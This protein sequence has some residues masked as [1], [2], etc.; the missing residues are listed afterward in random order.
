MGRTLSVDSGLWSSTTPR[1]AKDPAL[2]CAMDCRPMKNVAGK[3]SFM[4][5]R[6][7][8]K[9]VPLIRRYCLTN[10]KLKKTRGTFGIVRALGTNGYEILRLRSGFRL[11]A[12][13]A[14]TPAKRL[15]LKI[16]RSERIVGVRVSPSPDHYFVAVLPTA[17]EFSLRKFVRAT[18]T[19]GLGARAGPSP[20]EEI[21]CDRQTGGHLLHANRAHGHLQRF[22]RLAPDQRRTDF[23]SSAPCG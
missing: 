20:G 17:K 19:A 16:R 12:P 13:A 8:K 4:Y 10:R 15:N 2:P 5:P 3:E 6:P 23:A 9:E 22:R 1:C 11:R 14:L 21:I 7:A 18:H